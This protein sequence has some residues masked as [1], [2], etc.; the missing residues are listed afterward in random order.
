M[1]PQKISLQ[2]LKKSYRSHQIINGHKKGDS[3]VTEWAFRLHVISMVLMVLKEPLS[4]EANLQGSEP[5]SPLL[6][7]EPT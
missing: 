1:L 7:S 4:F 5:R 2:F 3:I 6:Q